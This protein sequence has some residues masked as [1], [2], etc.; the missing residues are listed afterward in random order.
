ML[1]QHLAHIS[2]ESFVPFTLILILVASVP[3]DP[4]LSIL[5]KWGLSTY[6]LIF[7]T[8]CLVSLLYY[9]SKKSV[10]HQH[11]LYLKLILTYHSSSP[12]YPKQFVIDCVCN[13]FSDSNVSP[14]IGK[15][16]ILLQI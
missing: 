3:F 1:R 16:L 7:L 14:F 15:R 9:I 5:T 8:A 4:L 2:S 6:I 10:L 13:P 12:L 11:L